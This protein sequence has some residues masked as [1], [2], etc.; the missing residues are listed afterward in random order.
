M[1]KY[2]QYLFLSISVLFS[3]VAY[4]AD[5]E[6]VIQTDSHWNKQAIKPIHLDHPQ[7]TILRI[8]IPAGEKL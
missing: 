6:T 3:S 8:T 2:M 1:K 5:S 4:A 7:I